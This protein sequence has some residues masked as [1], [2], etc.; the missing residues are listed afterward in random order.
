MKID[1]KGRPARSVAIVGALLLV[2][3]LE[4]LPAQKTVRDL[5]DRE[6]EVPHTVE[7]IAALYSFPGYATVMLGAC[8]G[9]VAVTGGVQREVLLSRIC[10]GIPD[11]A[12][13]KRG[14]NINIEE[15]LSLEPD[16]VFIDSRAVNNNNVGQLDRFG[17]PYVVVDYSS[18]EGQIRAMNLMG[19]VIGGEAVE[20]A[21][22][23]ESYYREVLARVRSAIAD[24]PEDERVELYHSINEASRTSGRDTLSAEWTTRAGADNVALGE[25]LRLFEDA[26]YASMEQILLWDPEIIIV[27]ES[28]V[29]DYMMD[30][31]PWQTIEA[32]REERIYKLP[33][34]ASRWGHPSSPEIPLAIQW[35]A[36]RLYPER[37]RDLDL[38]AEVD[39]FYRRFFDYELS[40][41]ELDHVISGGEGLRRFRDPE[42][43]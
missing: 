2:L 19:E 25:D 26:Y 41:E 14:G 9:L 27:N 5:L 18:I 23:Y 21:R 13:P 28:D 10:E 38:E 43:N 39:R 15:L 30:S 11:A 1:A 6:L 17:I 37:F 16:V 20:R 34:G 31:D 4:A 33:N 7:R 12:V 8:D 36:K 32:V 35:T 3:G 42:R 22:A 40:D 29:D 24:V